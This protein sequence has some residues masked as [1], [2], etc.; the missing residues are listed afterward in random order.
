MR[1][2]IIY[3]STYGNTK[4]LALYIAEALRPYGPVQA[5]PA[6]E[7]DQLDHPQWDI[8]LLGGPTQLRR[9]SPPLNILLKMLPRRALRG[10]STATFDTRYQKPGWLTGSAAQR[11]ASRLRRAGATL[12]LPPESF[13]VTTARGPLLEGELDRAAQWANLLHQSYQQAQRLKQQKLR[14]ALI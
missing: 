14:P 8:L 5:V 12:L 10:R 9:I 2:L 4:Q 6:A 13:F 7:I 3:D 11:L 1:T